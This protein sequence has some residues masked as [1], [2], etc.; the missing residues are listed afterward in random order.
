MRIAVLT[1]TYPHG[2]QLA[3]APF[4]APFLDELTR[5]GHEPVAFFPR[6]ADVAP[7]SSTEIPIEW[8]R[9]PKPLVNLSLSRPGDLSGVLRLLRRWEAR[10]AD[11]HAARPFDIM[12]ALWAV[13]GGLVARRVSRRAGIPYGV[14]SL[15]SDINTYGRRLT[16]R[17]IVRSVL[18]EA[19]AVFANSNVLAEEIES[20]AGVS[21][22]FLATS[23]PIEQP[24][25][26]A[27]LPQGFNFVFIGRLELVKGPDVLLDA[28]SRLAAD[29]GGWH[30]TVVGDGSMAKEL[31]E[32]VSLDAA[33]S[34]RVTFTGHLDG[35]RLLSYLYAADCVVIPSRSESMP[36]VFSEGLQARKRF[37]VADVGDLSRFVNGYHLGE[38]VGPGDAQAL[39][40]AMTRFVDN[41]AG[42]ITID[43]ELVDL[44]DIN[45]SASRFCEVAGEVLGQTP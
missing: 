22:E 28:A 31:S 37:I 17:R 42:D 16:T 13:P 21:V 33:L 7:S 20:I 9:H 3:A 27:S 10:V 35:E 18:R 1:S 24:A 19:G 30:L 8:S 44:F 45:R 14:W 40:S 32:R 25:R 43:P 15:G 2:S 41:G 29:A 23:R 34:G 39:A 5:L 12:L 36:V 4:L 11:E 26:L 6:I 38:V